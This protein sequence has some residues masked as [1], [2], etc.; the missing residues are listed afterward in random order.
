VLTTELRTRLSTAVLLL[1][2]LTGWIVAPLVHEFEHARERAE[3]THVHDVRDGVTLRTGCEPIPSLA[4]ECPISLTKV[5]AIGDM[6]PPFVGPETSSSTWA[7]SQNE[8]FSRFSSFRF[9]RGP[10]AVI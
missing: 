1:V 4:E 5:Q 9:V 10:P 3:M 2:V 6:Q 7:V 8:A